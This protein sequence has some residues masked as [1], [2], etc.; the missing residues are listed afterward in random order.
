MADQRARWEMLPYDP[1]VPQWT[2]RNEVIASYI[3]DGSRV[4]DIGCGNKDLRRYLTSQ[5]Y[6]PMDFVGDDV[7]PV[8]FDNILSIPPVIPGEYDIGVMSG[9]L[10]HI[11]FPWLAISSALRWAPELIVSYMFAEDMK[12]PNIEYQLGKWEFKAGLD[13]MGLPYEFLTKWNE[14]HSIFR[15]TRNRKVKDGS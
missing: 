15:I 12:S 1:E 4:L 5:Q 8:D 14:R 6:T 2:E 13:L 7:I 9:V 10:E 3:S 11:R